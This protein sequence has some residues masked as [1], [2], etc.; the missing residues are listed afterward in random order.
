MAPDF[1]KEGENFLSEDQIQV[2]CSNNLSSLFLTG[3]NFS[4]I[5]QGDTTKYATQVEEI[6]YV[7]S[8]CQGF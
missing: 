6:T 2:C 1:Q 7:P 4:E 8:D 5:V 3:M